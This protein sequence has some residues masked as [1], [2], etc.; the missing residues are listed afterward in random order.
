MRAAHAARTW[1]DR[2]NLKIRR[3][4]KS[5]KE[6]LVERIF[7][8]GTDSDGKRM[9]AVAFR[10]PFALTNGKGGGYALLSCE[11]AACPSLRQM[12][13]YGPAVSHYCWDRG[14]YSV[15]EKLVRKRHYHEAAQSTRLTAKLEALLNFVVATADVLHDCGNAGAWGVKPFLPSDTVMKDIFIGISSLRNA[16]DLLMQELGPWLSVVVHFTDVPQPEGF[17]SQLWRL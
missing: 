5:S 4:G 11:M 10:E 15:L 16:Y 1:G 12:G 7:V 8:Q 13:H 17:L 6:F 9:I 14:C 2:G 3:R